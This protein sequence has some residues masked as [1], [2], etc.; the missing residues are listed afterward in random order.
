MDSLN[1]KCHLDID[2]DG[3][4]KLNKLFTIVVNLDLSGV[5]YSWRDKEKKVII[6]KVLTPGLAEDMGIHIGDGSLYKCNPTRPSYEFKYASNTKEKDYLMHILKIKKKL[7]GLNK[8][9][10]RQRNNE[11]NLT[12]NSLAISTFY[13]N[14]LGI[15]SG[16]KVHSSSVPEIINN[17]KD[18][19]ILSSFLR[20][21]VDTD[22]Y[23][24]FKNKYGKPYPII[25]GMFASKDLVIGLG[26]LFNKLGIKN[27][28]KLE[29]P[30]F[31]KRSSKYYIKNEVTISG[32]KRVGRYIN[33]VG[34]NNPKNL[35]RIKMSPPGFEPG[36]VH[37]A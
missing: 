37:Q 7:F 17:S 2:H 20:G 25:Q 19:E 34:F 18:K 27:N 28:V 30:K 12:F 13:I 22:F 11:L 29:I 5:R 23:F 33:I 32:W 14:S 4:Y 24:C 10:I 36:T 1:Q 35:K 8:Y 21:V 6:S 26:T 9:K 16:S 3:I 15:P 31:D